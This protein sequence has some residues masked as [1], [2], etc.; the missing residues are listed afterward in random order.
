MSDERD[1]YRFKAKVGAKG[2]IAIPTRLLGMAELSE[3]T[4]ARFELLPSVE[5]EGPS[6]SHEIEV[7]QRIAEAE[8]LGMNTFNAYFPMW[9]ENFRQSLKL[10]PDDAK[11]LSHVADQR[12]GKSALIVGA[13]PSLKDTDWKTLRRFK[14]VLIANNKAL[15]PLLKHNIVPDWVVA[16]DGLPEVYNS[17]NDPVVTEHKGKCNFLGPTV[18]DASVTD[19]A[20]SWAKECVW[21][22]P[23]VPSGSDSKLW[24]LNLVMELLNG[25]EL[26]RHGGNVGTASWLLAKHLGCNPIGMLG[27]DMCAH[28]DKTWT[29][30]EAVNYEYFYNPE[31]D[32]TMALDS[33]FRA[34]FS[35]LA[36]VT[37][38][39]W[40]ENIATV[41]LT[42]VGILHSSSLFP[43]CELK[44]YVVAA[45]RKDILKSARRDKERGRA[46]MMKKIKAIEESQ[47]PIFRAEV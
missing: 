41:N 7:T 36:D 39:A 13:G 22:N 8:E 40:E 45:N 12:K 23:H 32:E 21:G 3:G 35:I 47:K 14:G 37:D 1:A 44:R 34:Y 25:L 2:R 33:P 42:P 4:Y 5:P 20:L 10:I 29:K 30:D 46:K 26:M 11:T 27:F 31:N 43:N 38:L 6:V 16:L 19:F 18:L 17:F 28:P 15:I 24:N 9:M